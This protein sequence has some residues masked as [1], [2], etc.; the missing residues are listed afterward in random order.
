M[1]GKKRVNLFMLSGLLILSISL[2]LL[3]C[4]GE[5]TWV[6]PCCPKM[7]GVPKS[8]QWIC[9]ASCPGGGLVVLPYTITFSDQNGRWCNPE[10]PEFIITNV[11]D[12]VVVRK[13]TPTSTQ[14]GV[15]TGTE[16]IKITK[17]TTYRL[18]VTQKDK[19]CLDIS[20]EFPVNVINDGDYE[21]LPFSGKFEPP[22]TMTIFSFCDAYPGVLI[23]SVENVQNYKITLTKSNYPPDTIDPYKTSDKWARLEAR[24][25]W[26]IGLTSLADIQSYNSQT[27]LPTLVI[28]INLT[29][30]DCAKK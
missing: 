5:V 8:E 6:N 14:A 9:P 2:A 28:K 7:A 3:N 10:K 23:D 1:K 21:L 17:D 15:Y 19:S 25:Y 26:G 20:Q 30:G 18:T 27:S 24:D 11:T 22:Y 4:M 16:K 29:C 12:N 13:F